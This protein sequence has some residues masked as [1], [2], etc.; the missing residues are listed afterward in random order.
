MEKEGLD[1]RSFHVPDVNSSRQLKQQ[2][3]RSTLLARLELQKEETMSS[4]PANQYE[5]CQ[6]LI[7]SLKKL[8]KEELDISFYLTRV[9]RI[10][11]E[12]LHDSGDVRGTPVEYLLVC[13]VAAR[14]E[15]PSKSSDRMSVSIDDI[16]RAAEEISRNYP[17]ISIGEFMEDKE[18][19]LLRCKASIQ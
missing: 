10:S 6:A 7:E 8:K 4:L 15:L 1:K 12:S 16:K 17:E 13:A 9:G 5:F 18:A 19:G 14:G 11:I 3:A 2:A